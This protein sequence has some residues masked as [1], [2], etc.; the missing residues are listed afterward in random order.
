[1]SLDNYISIIPIRNGS[2]GLKNKNIKLI[3][4]STDVVYGDMGK[5]NKRSN[6]SHP[7]KPSSPYSASK[8]SGF[9]LFAHPRD[10]SF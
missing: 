3:H 2:K 10:E 7:Y 9:D 4:V 8:A 1:M 5:N 6:E